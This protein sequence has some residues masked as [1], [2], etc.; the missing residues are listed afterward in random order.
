MSTVHQVDA[1]LVSKLGW[2]VGAIVPHITPL[3]IAH[4][5]WTRTTSGTALSPSDALARVLANAP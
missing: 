3:A 1:Q 2:V 4:R 5:W